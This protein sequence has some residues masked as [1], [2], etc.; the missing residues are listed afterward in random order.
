[1]ALH[2]VK[3]CIGTASPDDLEAVITR[4][5]GGSPAGQ[6]AC[7][8]T[9]ATPKRAAEIA[10]AGSLYWV[11]KSSIQCRQKILRIEPDE[12]PG[13]RR[14]RLVLDATVVRVEPRDRKPFQ[15]WRYLAADEAPRDLRPE[16]EG[17]PIHLQR[18]L[19]E[20]GLL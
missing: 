14:C 15:G 4:L 2:L 7:I 9:R 12:T 6:E 18:E 11:M 1:M 8:S 10:G 19:S 17:L 13:A 16:T 3:L 5:F 20:L